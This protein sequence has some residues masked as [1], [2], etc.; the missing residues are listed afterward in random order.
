MESFAL[1]A[2]TDAR[3]PAPPHADAGFARPTV[4]CPRDEA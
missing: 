4:S 3:I 1:A 2:Q